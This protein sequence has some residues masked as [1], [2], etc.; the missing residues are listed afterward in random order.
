MPEALPFAKLGECAKQLSLPRVPAKVKPPAH[1]A[2]PGLRPG[3][4]PLTSVAAA[5]MPRLLRFPLLLGAALLVSLRVGSG[6]AAKEPPPP[7][8]PPE[9]L[10]LLSADT[11][12]QWSALATLRRDPAAARAGLVLA[13]QR[14]EPPP[15]RWRLINRLAEF[16]TVED[17]P[18]LLQL[19]ATPQNDWER[20]IAEGT[21]RA[22][23]TPAGNQP[24]LDAVVQDFS[25]IQTQR[26]TPVDDPN[27]G[28]WM[29]TRQTLGDYHR[30]EVPLA[31]IK[32][33]R[34][35]RGK[36]FATRN[37][38]ADALAKRV[39]PRDWK[40]L[41]DR[42]L[43][44]A[45][46]VPPRVQLEGLARVRLLNPLQRP[47]LLRISL[48]AWFGRF[49]EPP[50]EAWVYLEPA[51][52]T[53]VDLPVAP[54]GSLERPQIRLDLRLQEVDGGIIPGFHKLYLPLQP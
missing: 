8:P 22:L 36:P 37:E 49:R 52:T 17:V 39:G 54:Q 47:L 7:P 6:Q 19:R 45:E 14:E 18:L 41:H 12:Q 40:A 31:V 28:K 44:S 48:D 20:R 30:D 27:S 2:W 26:S 4:R 29:L 15:G 25:F 5:L 33:L 16:G 3:L 34:P 21:A 11:A 35:L 32:Q 24:G 23:Y 42:L 51:S 13:L 38:L 9:V 10:A 1:F 43:A 53:T 46:S 50:G